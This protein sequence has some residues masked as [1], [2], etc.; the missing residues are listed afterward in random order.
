[1]YGD[2]PEETSCFSFLYSEL[3]LMGVREEI[4]LISIKRRL[5]GKY[6]RLVLQV[7]AISSGNTE[8]CQS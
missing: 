7:A 8:R 6:G 5:I 2:I 3:D 4:I 1:M